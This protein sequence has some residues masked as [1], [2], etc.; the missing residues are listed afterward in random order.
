MLVVRQK[1]KRAAKPV[2]STA[3]HWVDNGDVLSAILGAYRQDERGNVTVPGLLAERAQWRRVC[4]KFRQAS[5][6]TPTP[7]D[8]DVTFSSAN[9]HYFPDS[10]RNGGVA[11]GNLRAVWLL[12]VPATGEVLFVTAL[13]AGPLTSTSTV[14][15][16][17]SLRALVRALGGQNADFNQRL[18]D[19]GSIIA[20]SRITLMANCVRNSKWTDGYCM[21]TSRGTHIG[22]T[23]ETVLGDL[24]G[25]SGD[26]IAAGVERDR[27]DNG[28]Y[29]YY[30]TSTI[31]FRETLPNCQ[32]L[33][34]VQPIATVDSKKVAGN[35]LPHPFRRAKRD[36][37][38]HPLTIALGYYCDPKT[39]ECG[40]WLTSLLRHGN[41]DGYYEP[42]TAENREEVLEEMA[43]D[44]L[45]AARRRQKAQTALV[46][47]PKSKG[48]AVA[49]PVARP[50][51][52]AA[53]DAT[54]F[55]Q[56]QMCELGMLARKN[57]SADD[58]ESESESE[59]GSNGDR[60]DDDD[61]SVGSGAN[62]SDDESDSESGSDND[63]G[64]EEAP[65][66]AAE[67][68]DD[69]SDNE[70]EG[71]VEIGDYDDDDDDDMDI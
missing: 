28:R 5:I 41:G 7:Y 17:W 20:G 63:S 68:S 11:F 64:S 2:A 52:K 38:I 34:W 49:A 54:P 59:S 37:G 50:T 30:K 19:L 8:A 42:F 15:K 16:R 71:R 65:A 27:K 55:I 22:T 48:K 44:A 36:R 3:G 39:A 47:H 33:H 40:G 29:V 4:K 31:A 18:S 58:S 69:D 9:P 1:K 53:A 60:S 13:P 21:T 32:Y 43:D 14:H 46:L 67:T 24:V 56:S 26:T 57:V 35:V 51:R 10:F 61:F 66:A 6:D 25:T 45:D 62:D 23:H 70:S 12:R